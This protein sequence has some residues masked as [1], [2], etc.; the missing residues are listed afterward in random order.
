LFP[1]TLGNN[2]IVVVVV[3]KSRGNIQRNFIRLLKSFNG[4]FKVDNNSP[5]IL[6][7]AR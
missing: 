5:I 4:V 1:T 2:S 7:K 3:V 6:F